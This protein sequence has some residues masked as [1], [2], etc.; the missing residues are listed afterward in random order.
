MKALNNKKLLILAVGA[1]M[2]L[3][4]CGGQSSS[5]TGLSVSSDTGTSQAG[6]SAEQS[7]AQSSAKTTYERGDDNAIYDEVLGEFTDLVEAAHEIYDD[8]QRYVA[9][10][11]AEGELLAQGIMV[12]TYTQ[13]GTW[14]ITRVA[15][16]TISAAVHGLDSDRLQ[17]LVAAKADGANFLTAAQRAEM[18]E[19]WQNAKDAGDSSLYDPA[20][21]LIGKGFQ[22][23]DKYVTTESAWPQTADVLSTYRAADTEELCNSLEGL[24]EYDNVG[25]LRGAMAEENEDG[26]P[27]TVSED[28]LTYTFKIREGAKW[29]DNTGA[30]KADVTADDFVAGFQH[31]FDAKS[32]LSYLAYG[33][34][35]GV[36]E[37]M[38][39]ATTD[40]ADVGYKA[41]DARTLQIKLVQ[42]ESYFPSRLVYSLF[43]P[44]NRAFFESKGGVFGIT[45]FQAIKN[46]DTYSYGKTNDPTSLLY[47]SAFYC[48]K[49]ETT[50]NSGE[51]VFTKNPHFYNADKVYLNTVQFIYDDGSNPTAMYNATVAGDFAGIG[52]GEATGLLKKAKDDGYFETSAYISDTNATTYFGSLNLNR[53]AWEGVGGVAKSN[54]SE[55]QKILNHEAFNNK[56]FRLGFLHGFDRA[57]WRDISVGEGVGKYSLRNMYTYPDFVKLSDR[58]TDGNKV[59]AANTSY[60]ELVE[61]Y[62]NQKGANMKAAD[63]QDGWFNLELAKQELAAA[64]AAIPEWGENDKISIDKI[65]YTGSVAQVAQINAFKKFIEDNIGDWVVVNPIGVSTTDDYY[66]TGYYVETGIDLPQDYFDGS[67]WGP[68]YLDPGTYLDTFSYLR[69]ASMLKVCGLDAEAE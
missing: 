36:A 68:D 33:I 40:F 35:D 18:K 37:Y 10:A 28:G 60:G 55:H 52:L 12:P 47:N 44:L 49:W 14:A 3:A 69:D 15:P 20:T 9:Y 42:K 30:V 41:I 7:T 45:E 46:A 13:G 4:A 6:T 21:Y 66:N 67:G 63:G 29:V 62:A 19:Q 48:S 32:A 8:D 64:K 53:G 5:A 65:Y 23:A 1:V 31:A 38:T 61:F 17:Y 57:G 59:F 43:M 24:V 11:K 16:K 25:V 58:V 50:K 26:T 27:F 54:Q 56:D 34:I 22:I 2:S 39:G 51:M